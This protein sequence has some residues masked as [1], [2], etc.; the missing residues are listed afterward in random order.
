MNFT[1]VMK[2]IHK[3][4]GL[5]L[6]SIRPGAKI[7]ITDVDEERGSLILRTSSGQN[8]SRP[9]DELQKIW[10]EMMV[11][12]AVHVEGVLHGSG[13]SRNQPETILANL[14]Y[15]EWLKVD[16]KKHIAYVG[17]N[18]HAFGTLRQMDSV[19][20]VEVTAKMRE[21]KGGGKF[22]TAIVAKDVNQSIQEMETI[23][24]GKVTTLEKGIYQLQTHVDTII[25]LS[26]DVWGLEEGTY[27]VIE[28][29][30]P[31]S[32]Q[33]RLALY[34]KYYSVLCNGSI[35]ALVSNSK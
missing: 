7:T 25:F 8:R 20:A 30:A 1:D 3:L 10:N 17:K 9:I 14:P 5:E 13:T 27:C 12:P 6:N 11:K 19:L 31:M 32:T 4:V 34:G 21:S 24:Q 29:S 18:T 22:T 28:S 35:K 26:A 33:K 2:D 23:C 15:I 16:N